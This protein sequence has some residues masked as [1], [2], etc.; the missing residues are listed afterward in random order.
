MTSPV[1]FLLF[2]DIFPLLGI[3]EGIVKKDR[4][5]INSAQGNKDGTVNC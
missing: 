3:V 1:A 4:H 5:C 2:L